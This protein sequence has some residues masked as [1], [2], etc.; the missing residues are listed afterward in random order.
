MGVLANEVAKPEYSFANPWV[1]LVGLAGAAAC[2]DPR[3][4]G[5]ELGLPRIAGENDQLEHPASVSPPPTRA[6]DVVKSFPYFIS[7]ILLQTL[8]LR[9][10]HRTRL[11]ASPLTLGKTRF[12]LSCWRQSRTGA[13]AGHELLSPRPSSRRFQSGAIGCRESAAAR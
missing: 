13:M 12:V 10:Q 2:P 11:P 7:L 6:M 1:K 8:G 5:S 3:L 9:V 4:P